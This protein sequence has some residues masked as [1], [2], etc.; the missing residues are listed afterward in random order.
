MV[1][2]LQPLLDLAAVD[3]VLAGR[4]ALV[5]LAVGVAPVGVEHLQLEVRR[6]DAP[7][8]DARLVALCRRH[9]AEPVGHGTHWHCTHAV[10]TGS[11]TR[12]HQDALFFH[13]RAVPVAT[14]FVTIHGKIPTPPVTK[15][16]SRLAE[17][18]K[19]DG[20]RPSYDSA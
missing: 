14:I 11:R 17:R 15:L 2:G 12:T 8:A 10:S 18:G 1:L 19:K 13:P 6:K 7:R 9:R 4:G 16:Y 20:A 5:A 3:A